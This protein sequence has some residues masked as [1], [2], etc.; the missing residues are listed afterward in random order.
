MLIAAGT[1]VGYW[2]VVAWVG[3]TA[4]TAAVA[5][6]LFRTMGG[7]RWPVAASL[8]AVTTGVLYLMFRVWLLQPLPSGL[9]G[10]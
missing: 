3:Y 6:V 9:L 8:A 7:Y 10:G 2:L 5:V 4:T 1:L